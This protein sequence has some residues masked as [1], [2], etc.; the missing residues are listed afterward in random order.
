[1]LFHFSDEKGNRSVATYPDDS[2]FV[3]RED[4]EGR[5]YIIVHLIGNLPQHVLPQQQFL[6]PLDKDTANRCIDRIFRCIGREDTDC[7][8]ID[9][10]EDVR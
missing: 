2:E 6:G 10:L 8:L 4:N 1:M 7:S 9:I 3:I 5:C